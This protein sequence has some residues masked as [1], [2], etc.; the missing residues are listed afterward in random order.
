MF[1]GRP[2][3]SGILIHQLQGTV[4]LG[5]PVPMILGLD[6]TVVQCGRRQLKYTPGIG[7]GVRPLPSSTFDQDL[8]PELAWQFGRQVQPLLPGA[9]LVYVQQGL[10][11]GSR[12]LSGCKRQVVPRAPDA[13][14]G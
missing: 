8:T 9:G 3:V 14:V 6:T 11:K 2:Q 13:V 12:L 10:V 7:P 5:K 1:K 4:D